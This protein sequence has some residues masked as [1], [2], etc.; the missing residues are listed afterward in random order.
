[1][2]F[3]ISMTKSKE[4]KCLYKSICGGI[5]ARKKGL[6]WKARD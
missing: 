6:R 5:Q 3:I 1:M 2:I 4:R